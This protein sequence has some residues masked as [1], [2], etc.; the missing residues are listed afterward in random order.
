MPTNAKTKTERAA[1]HTSQRS[2]AT[3]PYFEEYV[4]DD[5]AKG[6]FAKKICIALKIHT[7]IEEE[8]FTPQRGSDR[9]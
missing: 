4:E 6:E 9:G 3:S 1:R 8:I 2:H 7:Q 5:K